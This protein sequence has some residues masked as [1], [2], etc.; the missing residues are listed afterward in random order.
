MQAPIQYL[1]VSDILP[2]VCIQPLSKLIF[3]Q[4][5]AGV[6]PTVDIIELFGAQI[7]GEKFSELLV[8]K[9]TC[10]KVAALM[11]NFSL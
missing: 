2:V 8:S 5:A 1:K 10:I 3:I 7:T 6:H 9:L 4:K 11:L